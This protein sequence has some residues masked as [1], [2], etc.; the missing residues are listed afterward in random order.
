MATNQSQP[1]VFVVDDEPVISKTLGMILNQSG[2]SAL[3]FDDAQNALAA[4]S[5]SAP[6]F[7]ITDVIM[8]RM[9][10]IE[11]ASSVL[12]INP[13]CRV[14][15]LSGQAATGDI[16]ERARQAGNHFEILAKPLHPTELLAKMGD[17]A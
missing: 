9:N 1:T 6:D 17:L 12:R 8:P 11:L 4:V 14:I 3:A 5:T 16:L 2:Y 7:L 10:G 13:K 15:L